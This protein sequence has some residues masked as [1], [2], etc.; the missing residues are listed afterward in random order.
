MESHFGSAYQR[1]ANYC[2]ERG[3]DENDAVVALTVVCHLDNLHIIEKQGHGAG[4][5]TR[6]PCH[7]LQGAGVLEVGMGSQPS[8]VDWEK[9]RY[10]LELGEK[11]RK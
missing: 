5:L 2:N 1:F 4:M 8:W 6:E 11:L 9:V 10:Y 7:I 3:V